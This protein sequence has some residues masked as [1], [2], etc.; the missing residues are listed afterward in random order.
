MLA[1]SRAAVAATSRVGMNRVVRPGGSRKAMFGLRVGV[2][3]V[4]K[5][6]TFDVAL[7]TT[8]F[9]AVFFFFVSRVVCGVASPQ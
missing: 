8:L 3:K 9:D 7:Q 1:L 6:S 5:V 2:D 4:F